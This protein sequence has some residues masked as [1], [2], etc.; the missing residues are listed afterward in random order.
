[1]GVQ[2]D[3]KIEAVEGSAKRGAAKSGRASSA[4]RDK[5][6]APPSVRLTGFDI[7]S[8]GLHRFST[9]F[10]KHNISVVAESRSRKRAD[11]AELVSAYVVALNPE[12]IKAMRGVARI[13]E[14][15]ALIFGVGSE[16]QLLGF[17][18]L[19]LNALISECTDS[20]V[21][22]AVDKT[23]PFVRGSAT[24]HDRIPIVTSVKVDIGSVSLSGFTLNLGCG[25]MA[26]RLRRD[27]DLPATV[28]VTWSLPG[29]DSLSLDATPRWNSGRTV[30]L[31]YVSAAPE[32]LLD[33]IHT[34]SRRLRVTSVT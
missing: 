4:I 26:L 9:C 30:G 19:R 25:G 11:A 5:K 12:A 2:T 6:D 8:D 17:P 27:A 23:A 24:A 10:E 21:R 20:A 3:G 34:Y 33:W 14:G 32:V 13:A 22:A 16:Y 28:R 31:Q 7:S 1:M 15:G 29:I 18:D